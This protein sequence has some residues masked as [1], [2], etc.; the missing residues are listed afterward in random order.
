MAIY[1]WDS[2]ELEGYKTTLTD[3]SRQTIA[4]GVL[5][6]ENIESFVGRDTY[7]NDNLALQT[8]S[9]N[10]S[11]EIIADNS[12]KN[13][14]NA[15]LTGFSAI[16]ADTSLL[17]MTKH[18]DGPVNFKFVA[19]SAKVDKADN[20]VLSV[21][22]YYTS[23]YMLCASATLNPA[24][25]QH[26]QSY[27]GANMPNSVLGS[28]N[29]L[30]NYPG[31]SI[32]AS[33]TVNAGVALNNSIAKNGIAINK[34]NNSNSNCPGVS[35][36]NSTSTLLGFAIN[37]STID[38]TN[39]GYF[40]FAANDSRVSQYGF[41]VNSSATNHCI[42]IGSRKQVC[43]NHSVS[44]KDSYVNNY[45][46]GVQNAS[47][48]QNS[49][50]AYNSSST[51][52]AVSLYNSTSN[53]CSF[54]M[55]DSTSIVKDISNGHSISVYDSNAISHSLSLY[56]GSAYS[57]SVA[58]FNSTA[59]YD[60]FAFN[61]S[62]ATT[63]D[64]LAL[65]TSFANSS[66]F[67][68]NASRAMTN[69]FAVNDCDFVYDYSIAVSNSIASLSQHIA[70]YST[71]AIG[72]NDSKAI[73][74]HSIS[75]NIPIIRNISGSVHSNAALYNSTIGYTTEYFPENVFTGYVCDVPAGS[76]VSGKYKIEQ[77]ITK[78]DS[79]NAGYNSMSY[80]SSTIG[81]GVSASLAM[82]DSVVNANAMI[83]TPDGQDSVFTS[84]TDNNIALYSSI[85]TDS[86]NTIALWNNSVI[87]QERGS[88][89]DNIFI[90]MN[91]SEN[92]A[93][94]DYSLLFGSNDVTTESIYYLDKHIFIIA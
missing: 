49:I 36:N 71:T 55:Y 7:V 92:V 54:A 45:S 61:E 19:M 40:Q 21:P 37:N 27:D 67:A 94:P 24:G 80:Y 53:Y 66:S 74:A 14:N 29:V 83:L 9:L 25:A 78:F 93:V 3:L 72:V 10:E 4:D 88:I 43:N 22:S 81:A 12:A 62:S 5:L 47:A 87:L 34:S 44:Y 17:E 58:M 69:S 28:D 86:K 15:L 68:F 1:S 75:F 35:I 91:I 73:N 64:C 23:S 8:N 70:L 56:A 85:L 41:A 52:S 31:L 76:A 38:E 39:Y 26:I 59:V 20:I 60:S 82:F 30:T 50:A 6:S 57:A 90:D 79:S 84:L 46:V 18:N 65:M 77:T 32:N 11:K 16:S 33:E 2:A 63:N 51:Y 13:W 48:D 42:A 89:N